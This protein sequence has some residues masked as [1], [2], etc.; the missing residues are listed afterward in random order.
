MI[1]FGEFIVS[2]EKGEFISSTSSHISLFYYAAAP[3][4]CVEDP[5]PP[6]L[7]LFDIWEPVVPD[8]STKNFLLKRS[9]SM[10]ASDYTCSRYSCPRR[11]KGRLKILCSSCRVLICDVILCESLLIC[12]M[13]SREIFG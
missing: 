3:I 2:K 7:K 5:W 11:M 1:V 9:S 4:T 8:S 6:D 13:D 10:A 12:A